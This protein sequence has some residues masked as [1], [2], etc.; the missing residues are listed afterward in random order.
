VERAIE[1]LAIVTVLNA[2]EGI[3]DVANFSSILYFVGNWAKA[4]LIIS[5][6]YSKLFIFPAGNV[7]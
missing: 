5:S 3:E 6:R 4:L 1:I 2:N 7:Y